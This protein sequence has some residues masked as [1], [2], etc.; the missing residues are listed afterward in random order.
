MKIKIFIFSV[1][2][3]FLVGSISILIP[4]N[5]FFFDLK[6][7][8]PTKIKDPLKKTLFYIPLKIRDF[9]KILNSREENENK[10]LEL[11]ALKIENQILKSEINKGIVENFTLIDD[12]NKKKYDLR[13]IYIPFVDSKTYSKDKKIV[14]KKSGYIE[15]YNNQI[16]VIF[17]SG[18]SISFKINDEKNKKIK[19]YDIKNN[20]NEFVYNYEK[21]NGIKDIK[22]ID[23]Y[24]YASYTKKDFSKKDNCLNTSIVRAHL[25]DLNQDKLFFNE[26][27]THEECMIVSSVTKSK[28]GA[29]QAGGRLT[30]SAK[31]N[32]LYL[33]AG[34]FL[35]FNVAQNLEKKFGKTI[36]IN[37]NTLEDKVIS[38]GHRNPQGMYLTKDENYL[39]QS[40]HGQKGGDEINLIKLDQ[41]IIG[42]YG[43]PIAS[44]SE[45][46][47][48]ED[49]ELRKK[50]PFHKSHAE[51]GFIEPLIYFNPSIAPSQIVLNKFSQ[52]ENEFILSTLKDES[53]LFGEIENF[54]KAKINKKIYIGERIRDIIP[55][56]E[57]KYLLF[58]ES[59]P[60]IG[61]LQEY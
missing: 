16:I 51:Y 25:K 55:F 43:W 32:L 61:I 5:Q 59:S 50:I 58:L 31:R 8:I 46:Y 27:Y 21:H 56:K 48:Y 23:Q 10:S 44:Y 9:Q 6:K 14:Q 28:Y 57:N 17:L 2:I 54:K 12:I 3:L 38:M 40:E 20:L 11:K 7:K 4:E 30:Y 34:D 37:L 36:S 35:N 19:I 41:N 52:N 39:I 33:T 47:G 49:Y 45:Y 42:N 53:L 15:L 24:L 1:I 13:K 60:A 22:I 18:K 26:F 29:A